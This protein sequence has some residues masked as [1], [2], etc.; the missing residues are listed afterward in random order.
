MDKAFYQPLSFIAAKLL[1]FQQLRTMSMRRRENFFKNEK[2]NLVFSF[3]T[4]TK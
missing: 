2:T 3:K 1:L 4:I